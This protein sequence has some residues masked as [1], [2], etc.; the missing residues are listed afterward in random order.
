MTGGFR[1]LG[2]RARAIKDVSV[3]DRGVKDHV[4]VHRGGKQRKRAH[5]AKQ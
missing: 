3:G 1:V 5:V 2:D 4:N